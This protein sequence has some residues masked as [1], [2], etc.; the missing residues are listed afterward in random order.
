MKTVVIC[1]SRRYKKEIRKFGAELKELGVVVFEPYLHSGYDEWE[2]LSDEYKNYILLGLTLDHFYKIEIADV[3]FVYNKDGYAGVS[4]SL[5][6]GYAVAKSK[7]IYALE[8]DET[9]GCRN[10]LFREIVPTPAA[11]L[12]KL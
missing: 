6:M 1:G 10:V 12:K 7:P 4:T 8:K 3:V 11:L 5:E 2:K 9:E